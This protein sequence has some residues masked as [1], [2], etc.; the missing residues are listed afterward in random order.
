MIPYFILLL[1]V[2]F[3]AFLKSKFKSSQALNV[4]IGIVLILFA[5]LRAGSVGADTS[6]YFY[7][8]QYGNDYQNIG[9]LL[10][11]NSSV[12]IGFRLV[13][14]ISKLI[15]NEPY[16]LLIISSI[17]FVTFCVISIERLSANHTIS[18]FSFVCFGIYTFSFNGLRQGIAVGICTLAL[19]YVIHKS[20]IKYLFLVLLA[21]F[22]HK[23]AILLLPFY[24]I[25]SREFT[26]KYFLFILFLGLL[27]GVFIKNLIAASSILNDRYASYLELEFTG[28]NSLAL[29]HVV[30]TSIF[31]YSR[32]NIRNNY[33]FI[34]DVF[35]NSYVIGATIFLTVI[36]TSVY[37]E[38]TRIAFYFT[39]SQIFLWAMIFESLKNNNKR[40][41]T[42]GFVAVG[43]IYFY[44]ILNQIGFLIPYEIN[45]NIF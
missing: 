40:L 3:L 6:S 9:E 8:Y 23:S 7:F 34:Y 32:K 17:I 37:I 45:N 12:E 15:T 44:F 41:I 5:G 20:F 18:Y 22:F 28:G 16:I 21:F 35:L 29:I 1:I 31:I 25:L 14:W 13:E 39:T 2:V 27:M 19:Y 26:K 43:L 24:F 42:A 36:F 38:I 10:D 30:F 33:L 11:S 4:T